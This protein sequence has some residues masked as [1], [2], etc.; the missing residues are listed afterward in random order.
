MK[1]KKTGLTKNCDNKIR[2]SLIPPEAIR[3]LAEGFT[4]GT[5]KY[6]DHN[7]RKGTKWSVYYDALQRHLLAWSEGEENASDSHLSHLGHALC[8]LA[9]LVT[10]SKKN[11]GIDDRVDKEVCRCK[12]LT[13]IQEDR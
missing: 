2:P 3:A 6:D 13:Q 1:D 5:Q 9:I 11:I 4:Y 7:W 12:K 8:C 10:Y